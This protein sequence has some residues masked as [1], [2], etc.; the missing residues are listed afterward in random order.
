MVSSWREKLPPLEDMYDRKRISLGKREPGVYLIE[1]VNGDLRA[2]DVCIVTDL[3]VQR[4]ADA[5]L[6]R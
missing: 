6:R 2:F 1:A 3:A 4:R 5:F